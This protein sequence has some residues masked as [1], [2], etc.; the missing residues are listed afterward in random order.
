[1]SDIDERQDNQPWTVPYAEG[2]EK[3]QR[4]FVPHILASH[5]V[6]HASKTVGK[7][8]AVFEALDHPVPGRSYGP[9]VPSDAQLQTIKDMAADLFTEALRFANLYDFR[10]SNEHARRVAE[11][12][13]KLAAEREA[14]EKTKADVQG[15]REMVMSIATAAAQAFMDRDAARSL[16]PIVEADRDLGR[17]LLA[18]ITMRCMCWMS[19]DG[20]RCWQCRRDAYLAPAHPVAPT[21]EGEPK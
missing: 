4:C 6:L 18:E 5:C 9:P 17:E 19:V 13:T 8:A 2:V 15:A 1:M 11:K 14:H 20:S 3:A 21:T 10:L 12:N 16:L 7:L